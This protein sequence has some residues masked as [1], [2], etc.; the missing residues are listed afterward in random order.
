MST[1]SQINVELALA[2]TN[3]ATSF[4]CENVDAYEQKRKMTKKLNNW[5][6]QYLKWMKELKA[7]EQDWFLGTILEMKL[8]IDTWNC[9]E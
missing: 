4:I 3:K 6:G 9:W 2:E 5:P 1:E 7:R 8:Y